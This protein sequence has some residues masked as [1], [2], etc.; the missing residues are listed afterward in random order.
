MALVQMECRPD[1]LQ[2]D[3]DDRRQAHM[4]IRLSADQELRHVT[5][6]EGRQN[7]TCISVNRPD[8]V[9][10]RDKEYGEAGV[11]YLLPIASRKDGRIEARFSPKKVQRVFF[12]MVIIS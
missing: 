4:E 2:I 9:Q 11:L 8:R 7:G 3:P 12:G 1:S 10:V 6:F 5:R